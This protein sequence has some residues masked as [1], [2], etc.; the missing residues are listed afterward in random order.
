MMFTKNFEHDSFTSSNKKKHRKKFYSSKKTG[1]ARQNNWFFFTQK[2]KFM[3]FK[4][5]IPNDIS[6]LLKNLIIITK[7]ITNCSSYVHFSLE[8]YFCIIIISL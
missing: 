2:K 1:F 6:G 5:E 4:S 3:L 7:K 8:F